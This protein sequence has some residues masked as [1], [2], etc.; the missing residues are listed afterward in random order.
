MGQT[1]SNPLKFDSRKLK[2][3]I[4]VIGIKKTTS[5][6]GI[7]HIKELSDDTVEISEKYRD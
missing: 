1:S 6:F 7:I 4:C 3:A 5:V 2:K